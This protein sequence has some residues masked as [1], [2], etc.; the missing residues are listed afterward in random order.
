MALVLIE[1]SG[2]RG[3]SVDD[4]V[5]EDVDV[6]VDGNVHVEEIRSDDI[7]NIEMNGNLGIFG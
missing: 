3:V 1:F 2:T 5:N 4:D 7:D 6:D